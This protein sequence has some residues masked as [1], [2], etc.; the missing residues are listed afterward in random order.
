MPGTQPRSRR[1]RLIAITIS[2]MLPHARHFRTPSLHFIRNRLDKAIILFFLQM[3]N[4][5]PREVEELAQSHTTEV[6]HLVS[7]C[8]A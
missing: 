7:G 1:V 6:T 5:R 4:R 2:K 3:R 8:A